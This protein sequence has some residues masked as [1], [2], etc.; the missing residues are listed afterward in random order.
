MSVFQIVIETADQHD[1]NHKKNGG[2][3]EDDILLHPVLFKKHIW[4]SFRDIYMYYN[5]RKGA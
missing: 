5:A 1:E 2:A 3:A 4:A